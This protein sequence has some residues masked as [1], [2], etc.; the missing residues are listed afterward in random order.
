MVQFSNDVD[1]LKYEPVLF[2]GLH[3]PW[4]VLS[5]GSDGVLSGTSLTASGADFRVD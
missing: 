3:L 4:Q 1:I 5:S 2:G